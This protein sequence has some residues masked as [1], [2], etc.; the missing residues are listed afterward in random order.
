MVDGT[1][2]M[3]AALK[4]RNVFLDT[5]CFHGG[6]FNYSSKPFR[7]LASLAAKDEVQVYV[8]D[9]TVREV[10][11]HITE[12]VVEVVRAH[13]RFTQEAR[14]LRNSKLKTSTQ[15]LALPDAD[16]VKAEL[17][18]QF[19][20]FLKE[21]RAIVLPTGN[22]KAG[23]VFDAYFQSKP[24]FGVGK[25]K[26]EF[27]DA[28]SL[29][30]VRKWCNE[31]KEEIYVVSTDTDMRSACD[32]DGPLYSLLNVAD[33]LNVLASDDEA[34]AAFLRGEIEKRKQETAHRVVELF[35]HDLGFILEDQDGDVVEV[36][37][38]DVSLG[39]IEILQTT[40]DHADLEIEATITFDAEL[41]YVDQDN[42]IWDSEDK[43]FIFTEYAKET[44]ERERSVQ[45]EISVSF[46][47]L[48]PDSFNIDDVSIANSKEPILVQSSASEGWPYK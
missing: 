16:A 30:A 3:A 6:G 35:E 42:S 31:N 8:T 13:K 12:A 44:V 22:L 33:F 4:T 29:A 21:T 26:D 23:P 18:S 15:V 19:E 36:T 17:V 2:D 34:M 32:E 5:E 27:P 38:S 47:G 9:I 20:T 39:E 46:E 43:T 45:V 28:F 25:K 40:D 1:R 24:P 11:A 7:I 14:I 37:V 10:L 48:D 41:S